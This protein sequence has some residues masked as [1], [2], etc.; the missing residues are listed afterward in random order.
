MERVINDRDNCC[1]KQRKEN[2]TLYQ[3]GNWEEILRNKDSIKF[4][5]GHFCKYYYVLRKPVF[6]L[7]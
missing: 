7:E 1:D 2:F 4:R 5:K 6:I 3:E